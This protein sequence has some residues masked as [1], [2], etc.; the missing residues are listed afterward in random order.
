M[1]VLT[2][3]KQCSSVE[4]ALKVIGGKWKLAILWEIHDKPRRFSQILKSL[5]GITQKMLTSQLRELES[6][7]LV[8]RKVFPEIP[9][10]VEY[11]LTAHGRSLGPILAQMAKWGE[12]VD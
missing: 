6:A 7:K 8:S 2:K 11:S 9:P 3:K 1:Q 12:V 4:T 5:D 10:R